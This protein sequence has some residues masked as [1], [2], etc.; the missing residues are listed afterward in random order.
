MLKS[1][2]NKEGQAEVQ[3]KIS[4]AEE[5][6]KNGKYKSA[7]RYYEEAIKLDP[8]NSTL[9]KLVDLC[10]HIKRPDLADKVSDWFAK[11]QHSLHQKKK[12]QAREAFEQTKK[13][14]VS[15]QDEN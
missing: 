15:L 4:Q 11:Y 13:E 12:A 7:I 2:S 10:V 14:E 6:E 1:F 8:Q 3:A 9:K 5:A